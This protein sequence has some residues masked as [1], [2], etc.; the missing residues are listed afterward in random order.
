MYANNIQSYYTLPLS[1]SNKA[2]SKINI[3]L[4]SMQD[5]SLKHSLFINPSKSFVMLLG[6]QHLCNGID[7]N[8]I[9]FKCFHCSLILIFDSGIVSRG[10]S[11]LH[12]VN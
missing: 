8:K 4:R 12:I 9:N 5:F 10:L 7:I 2:I 1:E 3:D 6:S 11:F